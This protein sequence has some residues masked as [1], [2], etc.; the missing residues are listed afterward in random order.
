MNPF[1]QLFPRN[2][3]DAEASADVPLAPLS[4]KYLVS[5]LALVT[6]CLACIAL[7]I[8]SVNSASE[9]GAVLAGGV[10]ALAASMVVLFSTHREMTRLRKHTA[11]W[12]RANYPHALRNGKLACRHC[13]CTRIRATRFG[14]F[15]RACVCSDCNE[16]LFYTEKRSQAPA[17]PSR[18]S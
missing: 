10:L 1:A 15:Y 11:V 17:V 5:K 2:D 14:S 12:Y 7:S 3:Q 6:L 4:A 9:D 16:T 13:G 18:R 8:G